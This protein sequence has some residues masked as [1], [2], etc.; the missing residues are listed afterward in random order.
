MQT[1]KTHNYEKVNQSMNT[2]DSYIGQDYWKV[3]TKNQN[4]I[5]KERNNIKK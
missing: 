4:Q 1:C 5:F 2:N 3:A